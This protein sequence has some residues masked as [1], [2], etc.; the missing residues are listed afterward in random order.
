MNPPP[1]FMGLTLLFWGWEVGLFPIAAIGAVIL[2]LPRLTRWRWDF[3]EADMNRIWDLCEIL[4]VGAMVY[5]YATTDISTGPSK[6]IPWLPLIF[7]PFIAATAYSVHDC[8]RLS[9]YFWLLRRKGHEAMRSKPISAFVP[10]WYFAVCFVAASIANVRD[11]RFYAAVVAFGAWMLWMFRSRATP[12][13]LWMTMVAT[14]SVV[15]FFGHIGLTRLQAFVENK[16]GQMLEDIG[17]PDTEITKAWTAIGSIGKLKMSGR[18]ILR[19][20]TDGHHP[21][22]DLLRKASFS[23]YQTVGNRAMWS[24]AKTEFTTV[25]PGP[26]PATWP[27]SASQDTS[28]FIRIS[29]FMARGTGIV[30]VPNGSVLLE[31]LFADSVQTNR[32]GSVRV[33][34]APPLVRYRVTYGNTST[35]DAP[36]MASDVEVPTSEQP[37]L[38]QIAADLGLGSQ[39]PAM[40]LRRVE[41]FFRDKFTYSRFLKETSYDPTGHNTSLSQFLLRDRAGHCEYFASATT[42]LLRQAGIPARYAI[43]FAVPEAERGGRVHL[44]RARHAHAWTLAYV[45]GVWRDIDTTPASWDEIEEE[46]KPLYQPLTDLFSWGQYRFAAWR[47]YSERGSVGKLVLWLA[48]ILLAWFS[49]RLFSRK[50]RVRLQGEA[51]QE[52]RPHYPGLDSEFYLIERRFAQTGFPRHTEEP[53]SAWLE[54]V[55]GSPQAKRTLDPLREILALH[56]AYRFDPEGISASARHDLKSRI[57]TWLRD[58][59]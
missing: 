51:R 54:R 20:D 14:V 24:I 34:N 30:P 8:V 45:D 3:S 49:W 11:I 42:L 22:P 19:L 12:V 15:G 48:P 50:R 26:E 41:G 55:E 53:L 31:E 40:V 52:P 4:F 2:E 13:W 23:T 38:A 36:P 29:S 32:Y 1:F 17:T 10:Y 44:V 6:F 18:V 5:G 21:P 59:R 27:L 35:L 25:S 28:S 7:F 9:T 16:A 33:R 58:S 46:Q 39:P 56:Y 37:A 57:D 43:G 47:Y